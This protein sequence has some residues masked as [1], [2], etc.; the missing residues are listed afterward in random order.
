MHTMRIEMFSLIWRNSTANQIGKKGANLIY[1]KSLCLTKVGTEFIDIL[2]VSA[3]W[4]VAKKKK[5]EVE[6]SFVCRQQHI[7]SHCP[8]W[9]ILNE[10][11]FSFKTLEYLL[12]IFGSLKTNSIR[13]NVKMVEQLFWYENSVLLM[14]IYE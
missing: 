6:S 12:N 11:F 1:F 14:D 7:L 13:F 3:K 8:Y 10:I 9:F 5:Q 4:S 2:H